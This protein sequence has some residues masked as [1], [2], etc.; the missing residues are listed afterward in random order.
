MPEIFLLLPQRH[1]IQQMK[2]LENILLPLQ[3]HMTQRMI[4]T[5]L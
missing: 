5:M 3:G 4:T 1:M 2:R